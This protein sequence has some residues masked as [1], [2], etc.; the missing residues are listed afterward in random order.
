MNAGLI[1]SICLHLFVVFM[2]WIDM[3]SFFKE[4]PVIK[5]APIIVDLANVKIGEMTNL[6]EFIE[7]ASKKQ[8]KKIGGGA[9]ANPPKPRKKP[10]PI[11]KVA[12]KAEEP[13][14]F[15]LEDS[16]VKVEK[17]KK[18]EKKKKQVKKADKKVKKT[19]KKQVKKDKPKDKKKVV[20]KKKV[21]KKATL[22]PSYS[23]NGKGKAASKK[24]KK[25]SEV[26][27]L[28]SLLASVGDIKKSL[29]KRTYSSKEEGKGD[30]TGRGDGGD[31]K[32]KGIKG[33]IG[34]RYDQDLTLSEKD[35]LSARLR[36]CWN[37]DAGAMG[38]ENMLI[39]I[40][41]YLNK[42]GTVRKVD[43][44]DKRRYKSDGFYRSVA[45]SAVR[46]V[47]LCSPYNSLSEKYGDKYEIW[48]TMLLKFNPLSG[49]VY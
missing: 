4:P 7:D 16:D 28:S 17:I 29:P 15:E 34:G 35:A 6:P 47:H 27:A 46:A 22:K 12:K 38:V 5:E 49:S 37:L 14:G 45:E 36:N 39:E 20:A 25:S 8:G 11:K 44:L 24:S 3:P 43:V 18:K 30:G 2:L 42:D 32:N 26:D 9:T 41:A 31:F 13:S 10:K 21:A 48:S 33:G 19:P 23:G 40:R 1:Y